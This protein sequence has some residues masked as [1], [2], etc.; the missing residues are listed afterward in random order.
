MFEKLKQIKELK[1]KAKVLQDQMST[2][3]CT[4]SAGWGSKVKITMD[5]NQ[6]ITSI[7]IDP[8]LLKPEYKEKLQ[9]LIKD[10][11]ADTLKQVQK[12]MA[13]KLSA[14]KD[15]NLNSLMGSGKE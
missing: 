8:E 12:A 3:Q 7:D 1:D 14:M 6:Q 4:G 9:G 5:G 2:I 10:A 11:F 13:S 15:F